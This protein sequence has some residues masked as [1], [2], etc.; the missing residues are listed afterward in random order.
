VLIPPR[1]IAERK[2][3][4]SGVRSSGVAEWDRSFG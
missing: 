2:S 4:E 1:C 3:S